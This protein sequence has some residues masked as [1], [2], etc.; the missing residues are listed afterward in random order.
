MN[1]GQAQISLTELRSRT[2]R[3]LLVLARN[4]IER[5]MKCARRNANPEAEERYAKA[6]TLL[7]VLR[8]SGAECADLERKLDEVRA[9]LDERVRTT[10][11]CAHSAWC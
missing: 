2:D 11:L 6:R 10:R 5:A 8:R 9:T 3:Q 1:T 4:E 7:I